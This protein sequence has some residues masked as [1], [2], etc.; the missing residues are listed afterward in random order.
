[1]KITK[2]WLQNWMIFEG[3]QEVDF[4]SGRANI[5]VIYGENMHGKTSLLNAIRWCLYGTATNR[6][7]KSILPADL[8][9][10]IAHRNGETKASVKLE[11]E[12]DE[13]RYEV[14]RELDLAKGSPLIDESLKIDGR[15]IDGGKVASEISSVIPEQISQFM[16]FDGELLKNFEN[17]VV[18]E[19]SAQATGIKNAIETT[20]GIPILRLA[21]EQADQMCQA[22]KKESK[23]QL[24]KDSQSQLIANKLAEL[25]LAI[26]TK[27]SDEE[28]L[29]FS[30]SEYKQELGDLSEQLHDSEDA[31]RL[32]ERQKIIKNSLVTSLQKQKDVQDEL[33]QIS[34]NF[35][36]VPLREAVQSNIKK[37]GEQLEEIK[38]QA[39]A[40]STKTLEIVKLQRS[41]GATK[42][43]TCHADLSSEKITEMQEKLTLLE[44]E[45]FGFG[46]IEEIT[47]DLKTKIRKLTIF[48]EV[49]CET[50]KYKARK[51]LQIEIDREILDLENG[52][53][54]I[55]QRLR[56]VD[57]QTSIT[58][59]NKYDAVN[60]EIAVLEDHLLKFETE[61]LN[62]ENQAKI[63]RK[64]KDFERLSQNSGV[65]KKV[66]KAEQLKEVLKKAIELYRDKMRFSVES[67]AT[68][69]FRYLTTEETFD[70]LEVNDSYGLNLIVSGTKVN[71]SAGA[72]QIV[73][74]S[75]IEALNFHG[76]RRGPMIMDTPV[77]RLD[78]KH[79]K[80]IMNY[81]PQVVTQLA[82]FAHSGELE[83][84]STLIDPTRIGARYRIT[85]S[86]V[87]QAELVRL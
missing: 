68:E 42:C 34:S 9:N 60:R 61:I 37:Y 85:R 66:E 19:G 76:R 77:G 8:I 82:I 54:E 13:L 29:K 48:P 3:Y 69:T 27:K 10:I 52:Q 23:A 70:K 21:H 50:E 14:L 71:R 57:E 35:W 11:L 67:R 79:R 12:V 30:I 40:Q 59:R 17:L 20:L 72:E 38:Q 62:L 1:M 43:P 32:I 80:N 2:I 55:K 87:F 84:N 6:Q 22:L 53:Y 74:M 44:S 36:L 58:T 33:K 73:A 7:G 15:V 86:S 26:E 24:Q 46:D 63:I 49:V 4:P 47:F 56:G 75:L 83:E 16:L 5:T 31:L 78:N 25:D 41:L 51:E 28:E 45:L 64:S 65:I 18:A 39:Q 81:L